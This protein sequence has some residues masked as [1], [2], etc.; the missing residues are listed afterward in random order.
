MTLSNLCINLWKKVGQVGRVLPRARFLSLAPISGIAIYQD[1]FILF[2]D[3]SD[4]RVSDKVG[5]VL[6]PTNVLSNF[7]QPTTTTDPD[8]ETQ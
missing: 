4:V 8:K 6:R 2:P 5:R 3:F 7:P 1:L